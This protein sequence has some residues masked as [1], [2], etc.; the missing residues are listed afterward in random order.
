MKRSKST[1]V[2]AATVF[3]A[4]LFLSGFSVAD[5]TVYTEDVENV[6]YNS[7]IFVGSLSHDE[8]EVNVSFQY[9]DNP[10]NEDE[11]EYETE[12]KTLSE[13]T[14]R[15]TIGA[16]GLSVN[17]TYAY[18]AIAEGESTSYG[19]IQEFTTYAEPTVKAT[20]ATEITHDSAVLQG[21]LVEIGMEEEVDLY[22]A[23]QDEFQD[24]EW[25]TTD[26]FTLQEE[27]V[28]T[29]EIENLGSDR[30]HNFKAVMNW[31]E[32][33]H[34]V[35]NT[36]ETFQTKTPV[37]VE[38]REVEE[39]TTNSALLKAEV[40]GEEDKVQEEEINASF[41]VKNDGMEK[42]KEIEVGDT[43]TIEAE[44]NNLQSGHS[45]I[46][47]IEI[48][49]YDSSDEIDFLTAPNVSMKNL[50]V[51]SE[52]VYVDEEF[53][54]SVDV[55]NLG[56][57]E[58]EYEVVFSVDGDEEKT[59][60]ANV[61][62][63]NTEK[64]TAGLSVGSSGTYD[65]EAEVLGKTNETGIEV[66]N[67]PN[68]E[69]K[70]PEEVGEDYA[71]LEGE[72]TEMGLEDDVKVFFRF[73]DEDEDEEY[74]S[75][76]EKQDIDGEEGF[77][78]EVQLNEEI[79]Y[80]YKAVV[81]WNDGDDE[82]T[83]QTL[84]MTPD[85]CEYNN[86]ENETCGGW[87][88]DEDEVYQV[89][90]VTDGSPSYCEDIKE[91]CF[92]SENYCGVP[93]VN[94]TPE[95]EIVNVSGGEHEKNNVTVWNIG[96]EDLKDV[97]ME[98]EGN[99]PDNWFEVT[100]S[101]LDIEQKDEKDFQVN[102]TPNSGAPVGK[103][104]INY[105]V[106][107]GSTERKEGKLWVH[108]DE[109]GEKKIN[110]RHKNLTQDIETIEGTI[111]DLSEKT[112][113]SHLEEDLSRLKELTAEGDEAIEEGN[114]M[115]AK[116]KIEES[117]FLLSEIK[118][119]IQTTEKELSFPWAW[120]GVGIVVIIVISVLIYLLLPPIEEYKRSGYQSPSDETVQDKIKEKFKELKERIFGE[121]EE[122]YTYQD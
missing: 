15:F 24:D 114:S 1:V 63:G 9:S 120:I 56:D 88:C 39:V 102:F 116:E 89:K 16:E 21:N 53:E 36:G 115:A 92:E 60:D 94:I 52:E 118:D 40:L 59:V 13:S 91:R 100:V 104:T 67:K 34:T 48:S 2:V 42:I 43:G 37:Y 112:N 26:N 22:F 31:G 62:G 101:S 8:D 72:V 79:G 45:Y 82:N 122:G 46:S 5:T 54:A 95:K 3:L 65:V 14:D 70:T 20:E 93:D 71:I 49:D 64:V 7:S 44:A 108:P 121:E 110:T 80:G 107:Y 33:N 51:D 98:I 106:D 55:E 90:E 30:E 25:N 87:E 69:T 97:E 66:F 11:W 12:S 35:E 77:E 58:Y 111:K 28:F 27:G 47:R 103:Y 99:I 119:K 4:F 109:E 6:T 78:Q 117:E 68:V 61:S 29:K 85:A 32:E 84:T 73:G 96:T 105:S 38:A 57:V 19:E 81:Q 23:W 18:R 50:D 113:V 10:D 83:G 86:W 74:W 41:F 76:S 17:T 75:E